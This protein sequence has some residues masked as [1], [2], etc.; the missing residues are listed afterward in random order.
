MSV[1][2]TATTPPRSGYTPAKGAYSIAEFCE[3][4]GGITRQF[5]YKLQTQGKAPRIM[6]V[7]SRVL[8]SAEAAADWRKEMEAA[9]SQE[10]T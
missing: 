8:I 3:S 4:H 6:R 2:N 7:G 5:F 9:T 1:R 10:A